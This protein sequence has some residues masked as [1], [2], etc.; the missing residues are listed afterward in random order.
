MTYRAKWQELVN[1]PL[2][3]T[4]CSVTAASSAKTGLGDRYR[5]SPLPIGLPRVLW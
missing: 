2:M 3:L 4:L 5:P 1:H